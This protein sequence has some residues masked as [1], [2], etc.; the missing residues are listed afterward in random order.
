MAKYFERAGL[1]E[2]GVVWSVGNGDSIRIWEDP[3][4]PQG[5]T[6]KPITPRRGNI[7]TRVSELINPLTEDWDDE[8]VRAI[9]W[10]EDAQKILTVPVHLEM[11][12]ILAWHYDLKGMFSVKSAYRVFCDDQIHRSKNDWAAS[13]SSN[14]DDVEKVW[15]LI[16]NM[17][18]PSR[19]KHFL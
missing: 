3:W 12:D 18:A 9:F 8:M 14:V 4:V 1:T 16:W 6:K 11:D 13:S 17:Q 15:S 5:A 7:L 10:E 2:K 19:L